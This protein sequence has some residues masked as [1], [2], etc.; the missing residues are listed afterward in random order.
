M[1]IGEKATNLRLNGI[2]KELASLG[3]RGLGV[4]HGPNKSQLKF[5]SINGRVV[6]V[7]V[8]AD[9]DGYEV[10]GPLTQSNSITATLDALR[11]L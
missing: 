6:I 10:F 2:H 1:V 9:D 7:Q 8:F 4:W 5:Y 3:A 11:A